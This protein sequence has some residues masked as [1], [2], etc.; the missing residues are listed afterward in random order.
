MIENRNLTL[1]VCTSH[2]GNH[3]FWYCMNHLL[4]RNSIALIEGQTIVH[5]LPFSHKI[6]RMNICTSILIRKILYHTLDTYCSGR[7]WNTI[8]PPA[9]SAIRFPG[10]WGVSATHKLAHMHVRFRQW[11]RDSVCRAAVD[12]GVLLAVLIFFL[13]LDVRFRCFTQLRSLSL[14]L[15][16][17]P[18]PKTQPK[19]RNGNKKPKVET[20]LRNPNSKPELRTQN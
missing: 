19:K 18:S 3:P 5:G 16:W 8:F 2:Y 6:P 13:S 14:S 11:Y 15:N 12:T 1:E 9:F 4:K 17:N 20:Q 10:T 7:V